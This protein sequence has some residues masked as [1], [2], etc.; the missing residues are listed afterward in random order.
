MKKLFLGIIATVMI[1]N[2]SFAQIT[3]CLKSSVTET[4]FKEMDEV[5]QKI[6]SYVDS[7][8]FALEGMNLNKNDKNKVASI[9]IGLKNSKLDNN[10]LIGDPDT[11][12]P[13]ENAQS[14]MIC[15]ISSGRLCFR[16]ILTQLNNGPIVIT[17]EKISDCIRLTW[18]VN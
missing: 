11:T 9:R 14:C 12:T 3:V 15:G 6:A 13:T 4:E 18:D 1:T 7:A 10:I 17:V 2:L 16:R 8:I 5:S